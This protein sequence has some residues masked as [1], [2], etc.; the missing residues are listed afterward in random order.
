MNMKATYN[1][2]N[3]KDNLIGAVLIGALFTATVT[4]GLASFEARASAP[5]VVE[6]Q[7]L[8][9]IVITAPRIKV[10]RLDTIVVTAKR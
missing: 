1:T 8:E 5:A 9:A 4:A 2:T 10:E 7:T 3:F 6:A